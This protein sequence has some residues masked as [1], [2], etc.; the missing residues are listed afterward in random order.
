MRLG[1][2]ERE[3][4]GVEG[5]DGPSRRVLVR[6]MR[7]ETWSGVSSSGR[8]RKPSLLKLSSCSG[9]NPWAGMVLFCAV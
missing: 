2:E 3:L 9:V 4:V 8:M 7:V 6:S 5:G 1:F